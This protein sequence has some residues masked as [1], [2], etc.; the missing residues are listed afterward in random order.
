MTIPKYDSGEGFYSRYREGTVRDIWKS[1][2]QGEKEYMKY[3]QQCKLGNEK[4]ERWGEPEKKKMNKKQ[5][6]KAVERG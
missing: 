4:R 5:E 3:G 1:L 6:R 2:E